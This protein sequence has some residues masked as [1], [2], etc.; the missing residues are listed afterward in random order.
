MSYDGGSDAAMNWTIEWVE[1]YARQLAV[2]SEALLDAEEAARPA[3]SNT[4]IGQ[5]APRWKLVRMYERLQTMMTETIG[6]L[7]ELRREERE[8][9]A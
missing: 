1:H 3:M 8:K 5:K 9:D 4:R 6:V 2:A 7:E